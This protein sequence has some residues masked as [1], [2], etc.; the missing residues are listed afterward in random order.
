MAR[1]AL[2]ITA[3][4][5]G[6]G[7][8]LTGASAAY[9]SGKAEDLYPP[10]GSFVEVTGGRVH[11]VQEGTGPHLVLLHGAGGNLRE[12]TFDLMG[13]LSDRYTVTAF[14]R[15]G[16]GYT[17]RVPGIATGALT[18]EGDGPRE[19]ARM[20]REAASVLG[21][22]NPIVAGHSFGGIVSYAWAVEGLDTDSPV[23]ASA[24]VS[25]AGVTMPWPGELGGY[26][27][28]NGSAFGGAVTIPLITA[29]VPDSRVRSGIEGI[30]APQSPPEG[31]ADY[32]GAAL[33]LRLD[34][35]RANVRQVNTLRPKVV[36]MAARYPELTLPIEIVH[37]TADTTVPIQVHAEEVI[38]IVPSVNIVP[39]EGVGH[40]P[41]HAE[42]GIVIEAIDRAAARAGLG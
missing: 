26:Y 10:I 36:E 15:P 21:I 32:V 12:F 17:D 39:L 11:Y 14:D 8:L 30:F 16:L 33:T 38:K 1:K 5:I 31:Y 20:L 3:A 37:G 42:P 25:L 35:F 22:E 4:A 9:R 34:S 6:L 2:T 18:T 41:H 19:Q 13:R 40:M 28:V 24:L 27:T 23:N 29:F 7:A